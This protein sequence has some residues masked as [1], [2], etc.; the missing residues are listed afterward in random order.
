MKIIVVVGGPKEGQGQ[1]ACRATGDS[2][3]WVDFWNTKL[4]QIL[5]SRWRGRWVVKTA[6]LPPVLI[7]FRRQLLYEQI[8]YRHVELIN[9]VS[10][11]YWATV[12]D[13]TISVVWFDI[14]VQ[15]LVD[16]L[17]LILFPLKPV[18]KLFEASLDFILKHLQVLVADILEL[19]CLVLLF[20][21]AFL[22][23]RIHKG[24]HQIKRIFVV[25][26]QP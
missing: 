10:N 23:Q 15:D 26:I 11:V 4:A 18:V 5:I 7:Q 20:L 17:E 8:L 19:F 14:S 24:A 22:E 25:R 2:H 6:S 3:N 12:G 21:N 16:A 13:R 1:C 9:P